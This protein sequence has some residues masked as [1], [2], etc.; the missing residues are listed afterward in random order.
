M[1]TTKLEDLSQMM[2]MASIEQGTLYFVSFLK[3]G[4]VIFGAF[5]SEMHAYRVYARC[6]FQW[7]LNRN[8]N[9][10]KNEKVLFRNKSYSDINSAECVP[11]CLYIYLFKVSVYLRVVYGYISK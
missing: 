8:W 10:A 9:R 5:F 4:N 2:Q 7:L 1:K 6:S 11:L 3:M